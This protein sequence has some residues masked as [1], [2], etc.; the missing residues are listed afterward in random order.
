MKKTNR[1]TAEQ[2]EAIY[3]DALLA[4]YK[5]LG[6]RK[7]ISELEL[8]H[9]IKNVMLAMKAIRSIFNQHRSYGYLH[10]ES[11]LC[12]ALWANITRMR[13]DDVH[14]YSCGGA[15]IMV[16]LFAGRALAIAH[17]LDYLDDIITD[18]TLDMPSNAGIDAIFDRIGDCNDN[19]SHDRLPPGVHV[20]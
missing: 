4:A 3:K 5:A 8:S 15:S 7:C 12:S 9:A 18:H 1:P 11:V 6:G 19:G 10:T 16:I 17:E 13:I 14:P 2:K 20:D